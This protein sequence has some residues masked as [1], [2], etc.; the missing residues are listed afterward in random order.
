MTTTTLLIARHGN[1]FAS[2][3]IVRR[4]GTTNMPL[5]ESGKQQARSLATYLTAHDLQP[6]S[7]V[8]SQLQR[9]I[10]M[11]NIIQQE[12]GTH[13][14]VTQAAFL[15]EIDYGVDEYQPE[16][17]VIARI[18]KEALQAWDRD[19]LLPQ[20]WVADIDAIIAGW[21]N[22]AH[23]LT[24]QQAGRTILVITSNGI[25]RFAP[26]ITGDMAGFCQHHAIKLATGALGIFTHTTHWHCESWN[27]RP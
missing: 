6:D 3:D 23:T 4:V 13:L 17:R 19:A 27:I 22:L 18:G 7:I 10:E 1:T 14:P 25:A 5:V 24:T 8:T 26:H 12:H 16:D 9:T 20:G 21:N 2:G 11:A 15:N